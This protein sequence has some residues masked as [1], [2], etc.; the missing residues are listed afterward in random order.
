VSK[1]AEYDK[2]YMY[3]RKSS[4]GEIL[5]DDVNHILTL[6]ELGLTPNQAKLYLNLLSLGKATVSVLSKES[7]LARQEVYRIVQD[8]HNM[9]LIEKIIG[10]PTQFEAISIQDGTT[11]LLNQKMSKLEKTR[12][13]VQNLVNEYCAV[14]QGSPTPEYK[15]LLIP[16]KKLVNE[17]RERMF[18]DAKKTVHLISTNRRMSQGIT[19]FFDIWEQMLK[20]HLS[21][22]V[23]IV[24]EESRFSGRDKLEILKHFSNFS[25]I[26]T[27]EPAAGL[28]VVDGEEAIVTLSPNVELGAS[29]VLWT[30]HPEVVAIYK[31]YFETI[32]DKNT[33]KRKQSLVGTKV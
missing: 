30:N 26:F 16:P 11:V 29:P 9:G 23:V 4:L 19:Y 27:S 14:K 1:V 28:L 2:S 17:T 6:I 21:V 31:V 15:F 3:N 33:S 13:K 32:W 5:G 22:R 24:G 8:L 10:N 12:V 18:K 7:G 20:R 25:C